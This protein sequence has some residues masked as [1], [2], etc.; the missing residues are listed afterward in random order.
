M[1]HTGRKMG[2]FPSP[3]ANIE[4]RAWEFPTFHGL[5]TGRVSNFPLPE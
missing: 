5:H 2:N 4:G 1:P 3:A